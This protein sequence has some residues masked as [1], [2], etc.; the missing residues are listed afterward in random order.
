[1][2]T[3]SITSSGVTFPDGSTQT[4]AAGTTFNSVGSY[5]WAGLP[6]AGIDAG[7]TYAGGNCLY[8]GMAWDRGS[9][10]NQWVYAGGTLSGTWR[11]MSTCPSDP[12]GFG[13]FNTSGGL[14]VRIA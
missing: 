11:A 3:T 9:P 5:T 4:I 6:D 14:M 7:S 8:F 13:G 2:P 12:Q 1:M 10:L